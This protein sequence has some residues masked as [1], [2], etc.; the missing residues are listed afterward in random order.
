M[1]LLSNG[2][3]LSDIGFWIFFIPTIFILSHVVL[4]IIIIPKWRLDGHF[5]PKNRKQ[6]RYNALKSIANDLGLRTKTVQPEKNLN[7][8]SWLVYQKKS[9]RLLHTL[10]K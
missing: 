1:F 6:D 10:R 7:F 8:F 2:H 3:I 4:L 9:Q 5:D